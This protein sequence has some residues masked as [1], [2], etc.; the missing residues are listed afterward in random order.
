MRFAAKVWSWDMHATLGLSIMCCNDPRSS[1]SL[2]LNWHVNQTHMQVQYKVHF[3]LLIYY[4]KLPPSLLFPGC[5][6]FEQRGISSCITIITM[7]LCA[8][9]KGG[10]FYN[11]SVLYVFVHTVSAIKT[12][13]PT[14]LLPNFALYLYI[15]CT[16]ISFPSCA[17]LDHISTIC[18][19]CTYLLI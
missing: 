8:V 3:H 6:I 2:P 15:A 5:S 1:L 16:C 19:M 10:S 4:I 14:P 7:S 12:P 17:G 18:L 11:N 13:S 9:K